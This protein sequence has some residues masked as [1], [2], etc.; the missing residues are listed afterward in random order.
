V[1]HSAVAY[2]LE[3]REI[4]V[5]FSAVAKSLVFITPADRL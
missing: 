4:L 1:I 3:D 5:T 2:G